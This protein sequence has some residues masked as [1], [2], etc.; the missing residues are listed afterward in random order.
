[1]LF[2]F[3]LLLFKLTT[4][5]YIYNNIVKKLLDKWN[6]NKLPFIFIFSSIFN[7]NQS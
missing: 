7:P 5:E 1:M 2:Y 3:F 4:Y 6:E